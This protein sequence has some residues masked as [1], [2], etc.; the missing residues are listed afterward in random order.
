MRALLA[1]VFLL[2]WTAIAT[3]QG[4]PNPQGAVLFEEGRA[5]AKDGKYAEACAKFEK[6]LEL[7]PAIG[8]QLNYADCHEKLNHVAQAWRL[9]DS[10]ADAEKITNPERAKFSRSRAD[11]LLAKLGV[12]VLKLATPDA[13]MIAVSI[14]G[15]TVKPAPVIKEIVDPGDVVV[16]VTAQ[17]VKPFQKTEKITAGKTVTIEVPALD[18][19][20]TTVIT[21]PDTAGPADD[22]SA[23]RKSR[24]ILSYAVGGAGAV[25][26]ITGIVLGVKARGDYN[27]EFD[28]GNCQESNNECNDV[29][30]A[31]QEDAISLANVGTVAGIAGIVL[32]GA[33][34]ALYFTAPKVETVAVTPT[35]TATSAGIALVGRF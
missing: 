15:R 27:A 22:Q 30:F 28:N 11:S 25:A 7:D 10:A 18:G 4:Q 8:T 13:P 16:N 26:L 29:G 23:K 20:S 35:A 21:P 24:L 1:S 32:V 33:G 5:L 17:N 2:V 14:G 19:T 34:A 12:V 3:A 31:A 9:F 6:S